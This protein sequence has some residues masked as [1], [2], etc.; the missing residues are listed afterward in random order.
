MRSDQDATALTRVFREVPLAELCDE[1]RSIT[2]GIVKV[3]EFV[4]DGVPVVRG[5]DIRDGQIATDNEKRVTQEVSAQ[6]KRT[7]LRGGEIVLNLIAEPGHS[8]IVPSGLAGANVTRDVAVIPVTR[9]DTR[10]VNYFL[11]SPQCVAWLRTHLQGSVTLKINLGTLARLPVPNPPIDEQRRIASVL[12]VLDEK[13]E[14]NRRLAD[15]T[16]AVIGCLYSQLELSQSND[17]V[18]LGNV[19]ERIIERVPPAVGWADEPLIDLARMPRKSLTLWWVGAGRELETAVTRFHRGD[20]LFG[21]IRPY[22]HKCG[23]APH[24]GVTNTSVMVIRAKRH[25]DEPL[26]LAAGSSQAAV[27]WAVARSGGTKM[28]T[29]AWADLA[30]F[31]LP[32]P[33][34]PAAQEFSTTARSLFDALP[35]LIAETRSLK[36]VR[37]ALLPKLI[38][39][40]IRVPDTDDPEEVVGPLAEYLAA[41]T[42]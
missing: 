23:M 2:Y 37:D 33:T 31:Q 6:F 35:V 28:P 15:G 36:M 40:Q 13:I 18:S 14:S 10:F 29:V 1:A 41:E 16:E 19:A 24:D 9:A 12:G 30:E 38:S 20:L 25:E 11:R 22:F 39:G 7:I 3:G 42:A 27:A 34:Q 8:A 26:I 5:G 4:P 32:N 17:V 21:A